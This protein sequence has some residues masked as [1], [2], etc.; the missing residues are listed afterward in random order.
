MKQKLIVALVASA[1]GGMAATTAQ[2]GVLQASYKVYAAEAINDDT[3]V[4]TAPVISYNLSRPLSGT[5][6]NPNNFTVTLTLNS[7]EWTAAP[8]AELRSP[9]NVL[10]IQGAAGVISADK[11]SVSYAFVVADGNTYP[12][13][14]TITFGATPLVGA[15]VPGTV[16][17]LASQ[18]GMPAD[19]CAP[20]ERQVTASIKLTNASSVEFDSND[21]NSDVSEPILASN[22]ALRL[23]TV[24]S[25]SYGT[26]GSAGA[27][28]TA[29]VDVLTGSLG[30]LFTA[31]PLTAGTSIANLG[32]VLI[33]DRG[34]FFD[35]DG[36]YTYSAKAATF[37]ADAADA[38]GDGFVAGK[39]LN[40]VVT[41]KYVTN[42]TVFLASD[43]ACTAASALTGATATATINAARDTA[44]FA[45]TITGADWAVMAAPNGTNAATKDTR[46]AYVCYDH[47]AAKTTDVIPAAQFVATSGSL[48]KGALSLE[49]ANNVCVGNLF[50]LTTNGVRVDVRNYIH[51]A[52][53]T[54]YNGWQSTLRLIN[55]DE[56]QTV[57][58]MA[59]YI[60][61]DGTLIGSGKI[62]TLA[63]RAAKYV[64]NDVVQAALG[65]LPAS[66]NNSRLR[67][68]AAGSS[69]RV[70]NYIY[71]P[72]RGTY[73][74]ASSAQGDE[75]PRGNLTQVDTHK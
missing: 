24:A 40:L 3:V 44:T 69:L 27:N 37:G 63:P 59:Q 16:N 45:H 5:V 47:N 6:A 33:Q 22:V 20:T 68:T 21:P 66:A 32:A 50:N 55:T 48:T 23:S 70:Q 41:G 67:I 26:L 75:G 51:A 54:A 42:G 53:T 65:A 14:S 72:V 62:A 64:G 49:G 56:N 43:P 12:V 52:N 15:A 71:D 38:G 74:E 28:E 36:K 11:K 30:T 2:A 9:D 39:T 25:S 4:L 7:G 61:E 46:A 10:A 35:N 58:V 17:K 8:N 29:Q 19:H 73:I 57:D 31:S 1:L 18:L 13:N 60:N 34:T